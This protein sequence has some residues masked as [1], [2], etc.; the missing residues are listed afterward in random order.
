MTAIMHKR[1]EG[2]ALTDTERERE[3]GERKK[4]E[5]RQNDK[6]KETYLV[7]TRR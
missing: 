4:K 2:V 7:V 3:M 1:D 6:N 5:M